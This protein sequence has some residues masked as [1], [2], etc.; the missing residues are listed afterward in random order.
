M[1]FT[2]RRFEAIKRRIALDGVFVD[3][4]G[5][6]YRSAVIG[7]VVCGLSNECA[8]RLISPIITYPGKHAKKPSFPYFLILIFANHLFKVS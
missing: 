7:M 6:F 1:P 5:T 4:P 3:N 2:Q 8:T